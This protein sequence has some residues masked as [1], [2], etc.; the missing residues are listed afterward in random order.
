VSSNQIMT[1]FV[2]TYTGGACGIRSVHLGEGLPS[3]WHG[4]LNTLFIL[5]QMAQKQYLFL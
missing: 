3:I 5:S 2:C 4:I 1:P